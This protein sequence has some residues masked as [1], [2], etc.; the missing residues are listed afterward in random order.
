MTQ[1]EVAEQAGLA[2]R[3]V[4]RIENGAS[5]QLLSIIR[6]LRVLGLLSKLDYTFPEIVDRP[7]ELL[8]RQGKPRQRASSRRN[9]EEDE[10]WTWDNDA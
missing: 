4:E 6:V 3:T 7:M 9:G 8:K 1:A 2:K 10:P 5:V